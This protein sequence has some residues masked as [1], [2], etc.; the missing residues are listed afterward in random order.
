MALLIIGSHRTED[1]FETTKKFAPDRDVRMWPDI[2]D[3]GDIRHA[4]AWHP[5]AGELKR[6]QNLESIVSVGAGVDHLFTD[7]ELPAVPIVRYID[8]DLT[9]RMVEYIT[10]HTLLHTRRMIEYREQQSACHWQYLPEP[11]AYQVRVGIM[12]IGVLGAAAADALRTI[13]YQVRGWSRSPKKIEGV[14]CFAGEANLDPFLANT[15]ILAVLLP[16]TPDTRG[17]INRDLLS[18]LSR[19][20]RHK[21]LPGPVL[22]NAGR[23]GLQ[24][25]TDILA[26]L[27][28][29]ELSAASLDVFENEPLPQDSPVWQHPRIVVTPHN[30]AES[31][32]DSITAYFLRH[33]ERMERGEPLEN[34]VDPAAGY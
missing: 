4:L 6:M 21:R 18:R 16:L 8:P 9:G 24:V 15:D 12:G 10:L 29:G 25:E 2:G 14:D 27:D 26:A 32:P 34:V 28:A 23:G 31:T 17:I 30:A 3:P 33:V 1:F 7:P 19:E 5:P 11:A 20:G 13:G 22:I